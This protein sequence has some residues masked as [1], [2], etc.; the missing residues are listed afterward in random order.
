MLAPATATTLDDL[1]EELRQLRMLVE[2]L[3]PRRPALSRADRDVLAK[4]LPAIGGAFGSEPFASR[5][6]LSAAGVRVVVRGLSP[7]RIGKLL[8]RAAGSPVDGFMVER[9]GLEI[10]VALWRVMAC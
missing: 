1:R 6:V 10:N 7:K 5:D 9:C 4:L 2:R 8:S 3:Q